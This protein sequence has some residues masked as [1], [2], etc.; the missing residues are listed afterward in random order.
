MIG[1]LRSLYLSLREYGWTVGLIAIDVDDTNR[2][3]LRKIFYL[4]NWATTGH[5]FMITQDPHTRL[6]LSLA[7]EEALLITKQCY[8]PGLGG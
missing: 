7:K 4:E 2:V 5:D 8:V 3:R 1:R 6:N